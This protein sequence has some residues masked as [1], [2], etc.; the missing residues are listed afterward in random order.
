M[1]YD[2]DMI[3]DK[4]IAMLMCNGIYPPVFHKFRS[5]GLYILR[6]FK[7]MNWIYILIDD[8]VPVDKNKN[9]Q[10]FGRAK[11]AHEM[12]VALI[13]K[14]YA[15]LHG[16]YGNLISGYIDE[17]VQELTGYQPEKILIRNETTGVFPHKMIENYGGKEGFWQFLRERKNDGCL[18]GC[19]IKSEKGGPQVV[20]G[21]PTGL[22]NNHA[23]GLEN[24][25][26]VED[27][28]DKTKPIRLVQLRNPWGNSEWTG[29]WSDGSIEMERYKN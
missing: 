12:W 16:C 8:R 13:E 14:A 10:V 9:T 22:I 15:K 25:I 6:I 26:E 20:D 27:P 28:Y 1:E 11:N 21:A 19:S 18:L 23:Y 3:V 2:P 17:G 5:R 4:E 24:I 7:N 29:A